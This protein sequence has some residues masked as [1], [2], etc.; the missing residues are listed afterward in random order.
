MKKFMSYSK[1]NKA[2]SVAEMLIVMLILSIVIISMT[3]IA[4]RRVVKNPA[5]PDHGSFECYWDGGR[6][7]QV[8]RNESGEII[9]NTLHAAGTKSCTFTPARGAM[10]FTVNAVGGG[11]PGAGVTAAFNELPAG[12]YDSSLGLYGDKGVDYVN[13]FFKHNGLIINTDSNNTVNYDEMPLYS[14]SDSNNP[15]NWLKSYGVPMRGILTS[16]A[17]DLTSGGFM[18]VIHNTGVPGHPECDSMSTP[19]FASLTEGSYNSHCFTYRV[20]AGRNPANGSRA[21][22]GQTV[23]HGMSIKSHGEG[24]PKLALGNAGC[25]VNDGGSGCYV[26][27]GC[28]PSAGTISNYGSGINCPSS[29]RNVGGG[30]LP[31]KKTNT[32]ASLAGVSGFEVAYSSCDSALNCIPASSCA[33]GSCT[34]SWIIDVDNTSQLKRHQLTWGRYIVAYQQLRKGVNFYAQA[35]NPGEYRAIYVSKLDG[36]IKLVPG[37]GVAFNAA[38]AINSGQVGNDTKLCYPA[39]GDVNCTSA[40][41]RMLLTAKGGKKPVTKANETFILG[42]LFTLNDAATP[43]VIA[44]DTPD[45]DPS[46]EQYGHYFKGKDSGFVY[47]IPDTT[48]PIPDTVGQG[49]SGSYTIHRLSSKSNIYKLWMASLTS[50]GKSERSNAGGAAKLANGSYTCQSDGVSRSGTN[51]PAHRCFAGSGQGGAVVITW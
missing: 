9:S 16:N 10:F 46:A 25:I 14:A 19:D 23:T 38:G 30:Y 27:Y 43:G 5:N 34:P 24:T 15:R 49:G 47:P 13:D 1:K 37:E 26:G 39:A 35:G 36:S 42:R 20:M 4:V 41:S 51:T 40:A 22:F 29:Y 3:P 6:L 7:R 8:T 48:H 32:T 44:Y 12:H 45:G 17:G 21:M 28:Y 2:F 50:A 31:E 33:L 18:Y 11:S